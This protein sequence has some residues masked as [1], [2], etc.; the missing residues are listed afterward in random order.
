MIYISLICFMLIVVVGSFLH[1]GLPDCV[2]DFYFVLGKWFSILMV[3]TVVFMLPPMLDYT[4]E[5]YEFLAFFT[6]T[7]IMFV[8]VAPNYLADVERGVHKAGAM[9]SG[10]SSIAW[11]VCVSPW[12]CLLLLVWIVGF[13]DKK[14]WLLWFELPCF[15]MIFLSMA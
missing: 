12:H 6:C 8:G 1:R 3:A 15:L 10:I 2:S 7:G 11:T 4:P 9:I 5:D 13:I 14:R